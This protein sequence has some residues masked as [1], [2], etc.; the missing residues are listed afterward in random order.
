MH[1]EGTT[2]DLHSHLM[3]TASFAPGYVSF[4]GELPRFENADVQKLMR[5]TVTT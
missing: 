2:D 3:T 1:G 5:P 4:P